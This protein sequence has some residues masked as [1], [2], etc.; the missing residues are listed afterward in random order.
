M[1]NKIKNT[2]FTLIEIVVVLI[3]MGVLAAIA[4]PNLFKNVSKS[5]GAEVLASFNAMKAAIEGCGSKN[6]SSGISNYSLCTT[7][8]LGQVGSWYYDV[9]ALNSDCGATDPNTCLGVGATT[10][11]C[12]RASYKNTGDI[13]NNIVLYGN[14]N[15]TANTTVVCAGHGTFG[16]IC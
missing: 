4:L 13:T 9:C 10:G 11:Y 12:I 3:I 15:G 6:S 5:K 7:T 2:G 1:K 8:Q 14:N 16:G